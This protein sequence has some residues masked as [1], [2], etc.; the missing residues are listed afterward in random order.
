MTDREHTDVMQDLVR[1]AMTMV[2]YVAISLMAVLV[3]L[4]EDASHG[5]RRAITIIWGTTAGLAI[6]HLFAFRLAARVAADGTISRE[7]LALS[8]AQLLGAGLVAL[9][10]SVPVVLFPTTAQFDVARLLLALIVA[11]AGYL[12]VRRHGGSVVRSL[13][14]AGATVALGLA[15]AVVKNV[16]SGH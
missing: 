7:E 13:V 16:V 5:D 10:V 1:E 15:V 4:D 14:A 8:S 12:V 3:A 2:F 11:G 6:A 9:V